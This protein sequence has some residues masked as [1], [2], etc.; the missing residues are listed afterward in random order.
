MSVDY[1][2]SIIHG[3]EITAEQYNSLPDEII[4]QY[5]F[6]TN[7]YSSTYC[8]YYIGVEQESISDDGET[9]IN[10]LHLENISDKAFS[11]LKTALPEVVNEYFPSTYLCL[12][13][14]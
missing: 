8:E 2:A 1:K 10:P 5:G 11:D 12:R 7:S 13:V 6:M 4:E 3:W 14:Y 9:E